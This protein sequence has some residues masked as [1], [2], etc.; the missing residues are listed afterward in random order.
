MKILKA[1]GV[2]AALLISGPASANESA[3]KE[4]HPDLAHL[5]ERIRVYQEVLNSYK[6]SDC[7]ADRRFIQAVQEEL[8]RLKAALEAKRK[9]STTS[10]GSYES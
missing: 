8:A 2:M 5:R 10:T 4:P 7:R 6:V 3:M 9:A 1:C